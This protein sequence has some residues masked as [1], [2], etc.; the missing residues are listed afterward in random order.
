VLFGLPLFY[1]G[2][3]LTKGLA[4]LSAGDCA[5]EEIGVV[6]MAGP[7]AFSGYR[8]DKHIDPMPLTGV[9][10]VFKPALRWDSAQRVAERMLADLLLPG[11]RVEVGAHPVHGSLITVSVE[12]VAPDR[13]AAV[14][15]DVQARIGPLTT[16]HETVFR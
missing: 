16:R 14:A 4:W 1:V 15:A 11:L 12:G 2:G 9:G 10:K 7:G 13:Q 8:S 5:I 6:A 3:A